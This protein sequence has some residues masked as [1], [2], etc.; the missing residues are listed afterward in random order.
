MRTLTRASAVAAAVVMGVTGIAGT[1]SAE[2]ATGDGWHKVQEAWTPFVEGTLTLP[3]AR[4]CGTFDLQLSAEEQD[5]VS[6]VTTR[7]DSGGDRTVSYKG[8]LLTRATNLSTG[9]SVVIDLGGKAAALFREDGSLAKYSLNGPVGVGWPQ[10]GGS[11]ERGYY[12]L[13]GQH[14]IDYAPDGTRSIVE[15]KGTET[16]VCDLVS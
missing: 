10:D 15:D 8:P 9:E 14:V 13:D 1:A 7:W 11:L 3:A 5:I 12:L 4:Y 2:P 16:N 6:K